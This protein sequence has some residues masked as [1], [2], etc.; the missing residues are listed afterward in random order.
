[1]KICHYAM[2]KLSL[3]LDFIRLNV[4]RT[5]I[6]NITTTTVVIK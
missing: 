5:L 3:I 6:N 1:M 4:N 2:T